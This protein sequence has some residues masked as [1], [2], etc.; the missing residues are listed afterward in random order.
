LKSIIIQVELHQQFWLWFVLKYRQ[1]LVFLMNCIFYRNYLFLY[2]LCSF[3]C[4]YVWP[5][6]H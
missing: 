1:L 2:L 3:L 5:T 4:L 6:A